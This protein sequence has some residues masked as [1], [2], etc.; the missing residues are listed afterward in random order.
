MDPVKFSSNFNNN[1]FYILFFY[2]ELPLLKNNLYPILYLEN[3]SY[4]IIENEES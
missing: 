1:Y 4:Y 2:F 3:N